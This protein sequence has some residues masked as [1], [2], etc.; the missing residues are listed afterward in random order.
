MY[1]SSDLSVGIPYRSQVNLR[2][3]SWFKTGGSA[4]CIYFPVKIDEMAYLVSQLHAKNTPFK[5]IGETTNLL[6][7]DDV[8]YGV[9]ISTTQ[10]NGIQY[11]SESSEIVVETGYLLPDL[12][13]FAL[14]HSIQGFASLEGIPGTIGGGV[15]MNASAFGYG[16]SDYLVRVEVIMPD[17]SIESLCHEELC[18]A[19]RDSVF[20]S[21][22]HLGII[23][24]AWF[25]VVRGDQ[26]SIYRDMENY[27]SQRHRSFEYM[28]PNLGSIFAGSVY[29]SMGRKDPYFRFCAALFYFFGYKLKSIGKETPLNR[30][31]LNDIA[32]KRFGLYYAN[33]PFS[34]K[35]LNVLINN[36]HH[37]D[38]LIS[39]IN[40]MKEIIGNDVLIENEIVEHF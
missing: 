7:L 23:S 20:K 17:G 16:I 12:S 25:K 2:E 40:R 30:R 34:D 13:R 5:V 10:L 14:H 6:F 1:I 29:R 8:S 15:F 22:R 38:E 28:Y 33:P 32:V 9:F 27:H 24:R 3:F 19:H 18:F 26:R 37:T 36:G 35:S 21:A 31:W 39:Y 11:D 4:A